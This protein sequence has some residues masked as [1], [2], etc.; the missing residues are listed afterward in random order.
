MVSIINH[1]V[2]A[3]ACGKEAIVWSKYIR[4]SVVTSDDFDDIINQ[5]LLLAICINHNVLRVARQSKSE[6]IFS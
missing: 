4:L 6:H 5:T 1:N 3:L 2:K